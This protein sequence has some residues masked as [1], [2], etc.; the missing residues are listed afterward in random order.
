MIQAA[1]R[2]ANETPELRETLAAFVLSFQR[3]DGGF[4]GRG[5]KSDLYY[6]LFAAGCLISLGSPLPA[7]LGAYL[8]S[9]GDGETLDLAHFACL[10]RCRSYLAPRQADDRARLDMLR[11][12]ENFHTPDGGYALSPLAAS[13]SVYGCFLAL[14]AYEDLDANLPDPAGLIRCAGN[15]AIGDGSYA[16]APSMPIGSTTATSAAITMLAQLGSKIDQASPAWLL[17]RQSSD[18]GF[19]AVPGAPCCDLL[20]TATALHAMDAATTLP[21]DEIR[22]PCRLFV[23]SLRDESGAYCSSMAETTPDCEYTF[24][25]LLAMGH[26][27]R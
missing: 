15:L 5:E 9:F 2:G 19:T 23:A 3:D 24:Y 16:N 10:A 8:E 12:L 6:T 4:A 7:T 13:G 25:G 20:S 27:C 17:N 11:R 14:G 18:G 1:A 22:E 26:L 21:L